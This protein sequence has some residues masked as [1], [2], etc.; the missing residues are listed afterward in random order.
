MQYTVLGQS[1]LHVRRLCHG[2]MN[3]GYVTALNAGINFFDTVAVYGWSDG[4]QTVDL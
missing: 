2:T 3:C 4:G 1:G